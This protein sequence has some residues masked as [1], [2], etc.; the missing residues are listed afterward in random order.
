MTANKRKR[1]V[2][3][4]SAG[5]RAICTETASHYAHIMHAKHDPRE[6]TAKARAALLSRFERQVDPTGTLPESE[7]SALAAEAKSAYYRELAYRRWHRPTAPAE[8][9]KTIQPTTP[10]QHTTPTI[11]STSSTT[12]TYGYTSSMR[13]SA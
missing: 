9:A 6:T 13:L 3:T 4:E 5:P 8:A 1:D 10:T 7:R 11:H 12:Q 2:D